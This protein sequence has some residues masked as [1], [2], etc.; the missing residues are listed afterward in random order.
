[1]EMGW[2]KFERRSLVTRWCSLKLFGSR[3]I[4]PF[5]FYRERERGGSKAHRTR[6][7]KFPSELIRV[8]SFFCYRNNAVMKR[9]CWRKRSANGDVSS[10]LF[11][12][13][14]SSKFV[15]SRRTFSFGT[16]AEKLRA[17]IDPSPDTINFSLDKQIRIVNLIIANRFFQELRFNMKIHRN[18]HSISNGRRHVEHCRALHLSRSL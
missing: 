5:F 16:R 9:R 18:V 15:L 10:A 1:M 3:V 7:S 12:F 17:L 4:L 2:K 13:V 6:V 14:F 8:Y 11:S